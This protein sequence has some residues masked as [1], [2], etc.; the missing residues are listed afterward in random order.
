[1]MDHQLATMAAHL[2]LSDGDFSAA[3]A[4]RIAAEVRG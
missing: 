2:G 3:T 1:M 4:K